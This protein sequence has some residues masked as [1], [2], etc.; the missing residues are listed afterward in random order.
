MQKNDTFYTGCLK[1]TVS[2]LKDEFFDQF[3]DDF[4]LVKI[5]KHQ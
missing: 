1:I 4:S 2:T 5:L 3:K